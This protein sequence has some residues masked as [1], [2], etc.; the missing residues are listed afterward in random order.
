MGKQ[1]RTGAATMLLV[2]RAS[3]IS[4]RRPTKLIRLPLINPL[5]NGLIYIIDKKSFRKVTDTK[6]IV[7]VKQGYDKNNPPKSIFSRIDATELQTL[8]IIIFSLTG[9]FGQD[10]FLGKVS[11]TEKVSVF[12]LE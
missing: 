10:I 7:T 1:G 11:Y 9:F 6:D 2:R 8:G 5:I 12:N 3:Y 4:G